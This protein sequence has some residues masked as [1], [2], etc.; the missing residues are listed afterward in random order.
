MVGF[1]L[2]RVRARRLL[3]AAALVTVLLTTCVPAALATLAA[4]TGAIGDAG[5]R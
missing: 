1:T 3:F 4:F 2:S 5:P